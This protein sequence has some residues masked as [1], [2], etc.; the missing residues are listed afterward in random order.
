[1]T[2]CC[3]WATHASMSLSKQED[4]TV[5][6]MLRAPIVSL[7]KT[8]LSFA[9]QLV[10]TISLSQTVTLTNIDKQVIDISSIAITGA[11]SSDFT[12]TSTCDSSLA[13]GAECTI[14]TTLTPTTIGSPALKI[15]KAV[16]AKGG[17]LAGCSPWL[18]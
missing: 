10:G 15:G 4:L 8:N 16:F 12:R 6:V 18:G 14:N 2:A 1:M 17:L 7:S 9:L 13:P 11:N 3:L 5:S